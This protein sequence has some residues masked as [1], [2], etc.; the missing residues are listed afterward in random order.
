MTDINMI[1]S[2]SDKIKSLKFPIITFGVVFLLVIFVFW[3]VLAR[4][5]GSKLLRNNLAQIFDALNQKGYDIAYDDIEFS[6][7]SPFHIMKIQNF[8]LYHSDENGNRWEWNVPE[9]S[10]NA[11]LLNYKSVS[12]YF[13]PAQSVVVNQDKFPF[14]AR[15]LTANA[16]FKNGALYSFLFNAGNIVF[17]NGAK[18]KNMKSAIQQ[19]DDETY[20]I[21]FDV[22]HVELIEGKSWNMS[23]AIEEIYIEMTTNKKFSDTGS[24]YD[25]LLTWQKDGG[26]FDVQRLIVNWL[27]LVLVGKGKL[28]FNAQLEPKLSL[29]TTSK[30]AELTLDNLGNAQIFDSKNVFVAKILLSTKQKEWDAQGNKEG[31]FSLPISFSEGQFDIENISMLPEGK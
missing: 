7:I 27:P 15:E 26:R 21:K 6:S 28:S 22:R 4:A 12:F 16:Y 19:N 3:V 1:F 14:E 18:I 10:L 23:N 31:T 8:K 5:Y 9:V 29:V 13:S 24:F 20:E 11:N 17:S 30:G 2:K 25:S